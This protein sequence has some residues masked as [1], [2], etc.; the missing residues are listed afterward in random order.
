MRIELTTFR[1][2]VCCST[3]RAMSQCIDDLLRFELR[4]FGTKIQRTNQL[5]YRS[6]F[7]CSD[8]DS[9]QDYTSRLHFVRVGCLSNYTIRAYF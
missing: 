8:L 2:S 3:Y 4:S 6:M 1:I 9:N 5:Y 7:Q